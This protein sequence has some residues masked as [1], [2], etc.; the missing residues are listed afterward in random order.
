MM[1]TA[2]IS[3]AIRTRI[4]R[5]RVRAITTNMVP[6]PNKDTIKGVMDTMMSRMCDAARKQ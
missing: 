2:I 3:K 5:T 4:T 6:T 1:A